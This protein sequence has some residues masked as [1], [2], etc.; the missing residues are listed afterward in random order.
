MSAHHS[1]R[2][3]GEEKT[4]VITTGIGTCDHEPYFC[5][6][7]NHPLFTQCEG[8]GFFVIFFLSR[9]SLVV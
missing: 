7:Y 4:V 8:S 2:I 1:I 9:S 3:V 5:S 6:I